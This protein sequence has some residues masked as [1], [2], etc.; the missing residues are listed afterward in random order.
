MASR[1]RRL[2]T[3][4]SALVLTFA[5]AGGAIILTGVNRP[6]HDAGSSLG[7]SERVLGSHLV[8]SATPSKPPVQPTSQPALSAP[9]LASSLVLTNS[10]GKQC[11]GAQT[12]VNC[13][14]QTIGCR[15]ETISLA[16]H[17]SFAYGVNAQ[18]KR[19]GLPADQH[20]GVSLGEIET[21]T[22]QIKCTGQRYM[23][24]MVDSLGRAQQ[25]TMTAEM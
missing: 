3:A 1:G 10:H 17:S 21:I 2:S 22:A 5:L 15:W 12:I 8:P 13:C 16:P 20:P 14:T 18:R 23:V 11:I 7:V 4:V 24:T 9:S 25:V 6:L 19:M